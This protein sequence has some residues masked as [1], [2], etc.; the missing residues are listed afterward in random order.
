MDSNKTNVSNYSL[1]LESTVVDNRPSNLNLGEITLNQL[2]IAKKQFCAEYKA[3]NWAL[4]GCQD[5]PY[6]N[7]SN[8][9]EKVDSSWL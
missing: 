4:S 2:E 9:W 7:D 6:A 5:I 1:E 8:L 3:N